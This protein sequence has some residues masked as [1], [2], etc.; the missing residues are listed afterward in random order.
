M[1]LEEGG[2]SSQ[3]RNECPSCVGTLGK[4]F[5]SHPP[6]ACAWD[7]GQGAQIRSLKSFH[8][9]RE[10]SSRGV[11]DHHKEQLILLRITSTKCRSHAKNKTLTFHKN[12]FTNEGRGGEAKRR[13]FPLLLTQ[14]SLLNP[15]ISLN[16]RVNSLGRYPNFTDKRSAHKW[17]RQNLKTDVVIN[18]KPVFLAILTGF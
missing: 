14:E 9:W 2:R 13:G 16:L 15:I 8:G 5:L 3:E 1:I 6:R 17:Q 10:R 4:L 18:S 12:L 7:S 11:W